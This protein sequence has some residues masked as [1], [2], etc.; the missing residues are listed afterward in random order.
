LR[1]RKLALIALTAVLGLFSSGHFLCVLAARW[2]GRDAAA[3]R[4]FLSNTASLSA[5]GY[6]HNPA[7]PAIRPWDEEP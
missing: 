3:G 7:E 5:L 2:L 6:E 1:T 4:F